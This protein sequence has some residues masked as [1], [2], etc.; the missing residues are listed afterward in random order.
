MAMLD[1][2]R[3]RNTCAPTKHLP[4]EIRRALKAASMRPVRNQCYAT[5]A[6]L[7]MHGEMPLLYVEGWA[8]WEGH[9]IA[10][11]WVRH[12]NLGDVDLLVESGYEDGVFYDAVRVLT[13]AEVARHFAST[14]HWGP[15]SDEL[16]DAPHLVRA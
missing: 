9:N 1:Y 15:W 6:K 2:I 11:A 8:R 14:G 7:V 5:A 4:P 13:A 12:P 16:V 10:H 3:R